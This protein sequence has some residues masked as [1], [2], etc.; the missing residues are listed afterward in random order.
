[1]RLLR[2]Q[3]HT[4]ESGGGEWEGGGGEGEG[5]GEEEVGRELLRR[6]SRGWRPLQKVKRLWQPLRS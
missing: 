5:A 6:R 1:M 3:L 4:R 2:A